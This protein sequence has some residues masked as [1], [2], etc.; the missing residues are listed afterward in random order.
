MPDVRLVSVTYRG[1]KVRVTGLAWGSVPAP[2]DPQPV[3]PVQGVWALA[4]R[5]EF[6]AWV[7]G[8]YSVGAWWGDVNDDGAVNYDVAEGALRIFP[9]RNAATG[10][11]INRTITSEG[12][13]VSSPAARYHLEVRFKLKAGAGRFPAVWL[14][15]HFQDQAPARPELDLM[16]TGT[17][18]W[19][20]DGANPLRVKATTWTDTGIDAGQPEP[21][22][23]TSQGSEYLVPGGL[24]G[25]WHT[26]GATVDA[27]AQTVT[28]Y[29]NDVQIGQHTSA[30][31]TKPLHLYLDEWFGGGFNEGTPPDPAALEA[32]ADPVE[33]DYWRV[34]TQAFHAPAPAPAPSASNPLTTA[35]QGVRT[36]KVSTDAD[37]DAVPWATLTAG[38]V[39]NI[40]YRAEPYRFIVRVRARGTAASPVIIN[41]VTDA[42]G[43][44]PIF[45][46]SGARVPAGMPVGWRADLAPVQF[47]PPGGRLN[48]LVARASTSSAGC[49]EWS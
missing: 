3:A 22:G 42:S 24:V 30:S 9:K 21:N 23:Q 47:Q 36:F 35:L 15:N 28:Y 4:A 8:R 41:G 26:C 17:G 32:A 12:Y 39:V 48:G 37:M 10:L 43:N 11:L 2:S 19:W 5:D 40:H 1:A 13:W 31:T 46:G 49:F 38:D 34:W 44:R 16:E 18:P 29:I 6:E 25:H 27:Q 45:H 7:P 33:F 14:H 20:G